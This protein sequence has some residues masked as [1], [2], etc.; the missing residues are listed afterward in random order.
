M[1]LFPHRI[2]NVVHH[3]RVK[4]EDGN[5]QW[6]HPTSHEIVGRG[7]NIIFSLPG[8]FALL[9]SFLTLR[10]SFQSFRNTVLKIFFAYQ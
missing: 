9:I 1:P 3:V 4:D 5:F 7:K 2:P 10:N 8:A 6:T